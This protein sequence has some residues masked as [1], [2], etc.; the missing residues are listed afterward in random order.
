M[1][2]HHYYS[3]TVAIVAVAAFILLVLYSAL[4]NPYGRASRVKNP[5]DTE[6]RG[7]NIRLYKRFDLKIRKNLFWRSF[8]YAKCAWHIVSNV[9]AGKKAERGTV[10]SVIRDIHQIRFDPKKPYLIS[11]DHF[12]VLYP[13]NLGVFYYATLDSRSTLDKTDWE[14][15]QRIYLQS[16]AYAL[17]A[18]KENGDCTTTIVPVGSY[19]A[20]CINI[21]HYPS[22]ALYGILFAL[23]ALT[24]NSFFERRYPFESENAFVLETKD[25]TQKLLDE[26]HELI[27]HLVRKYHEQIF[28]TEAGLVRADI[29]I[30][31]AKDIT[32]R[33]SAFYDNVIFWKTFQLAR[34][35]GIEN[36]PAIDLAGLK[37]RI[38]KTY[39][40]EEGG[41]FLEDRSQESVAEKYYSADW[42]SAYFTGLL[43]TTKPDERRYLERAVEH[44]IA[45]KL[46]MPFPL[47][48]QGADRAN[49]QV[50]LVRLVV[51]SYGGTAIWSF[52]GAEFIKLLVALSEYSSDSAF[53]DR[54]GRHIDAYQKNM[55]RFRGY[56]EVY[57]TKGSMLRTLFYNSVRQT[58]WVVGFEQAVSMFKAMKLRKSLS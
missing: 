27:A 18:F 1:I 9:H 47:R 49:R 57:E 42:L 23:S 51:A 56:P 45:E 14:M 4:S 24:D 37:E 22:D 8:A 5:F 44:T 55:L 2:H 46:D 13:R 10:E 26:N 15:R 19:A 52:W 28:D 53:L 34:T 21:Y 12:N 50:P 3:D 16:V 38:L 41:Y 54:A 25:A 43:D 35:L 30:S 33:T 36:I 7:K 32:V 29:H 20:T 58:G 39:W 6:R 31:S 40:Y 11:G 17:A 48:Y